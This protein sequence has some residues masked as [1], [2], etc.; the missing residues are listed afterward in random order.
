MCVLLLIFFFTSFI[1]L[2]KGMILCSRKLERDF[3]IDK[4]PNWHYLMAVGLSLFVSVALRQE[5]F[6]IQWMVILLL[7]GGLL[8]TEE[9]L[10]EKQV[11]NLLFLPLITPL[12][13]LMALK[14]PPGAVPGVLL[15][16]V[17]QLAVFQFLYGRADAIL[18]S[19]FM[20]ALG[21]F[22]AGLVIILFF[23][24]WALI[25]S[26]IVQLIK[27]NFNKKG[28]FKEPIPYTPYLYAAFIFSL[29]GVLL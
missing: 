23:M 4:P 29:G 7:S 12:A 2:E 16:A 20:I 15:P 8:I 24:L 18:T 10:R 21:I 28:N 27:G 9:D 19:V 22:G 11:M 6:L 25:L 13:V 26:G 14:C 17:I 5:K 1:L 3:P